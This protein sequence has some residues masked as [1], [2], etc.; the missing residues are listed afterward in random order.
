MTAVAGALL[1]G[2]LAAE[3]QRAGRIYRIGVF[4]VGD[5]IPPGLETLRDGLKTL[6]Y[7]EMD[8]S[9]YVIGYTTTVAPVPHFSA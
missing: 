2:P 1:A 5:H 3:A 4:H 7:E 8:P 9:V 6:G